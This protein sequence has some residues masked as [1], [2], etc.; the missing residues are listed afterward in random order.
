MAKQDKMRWRDL[1][2]LI[3]SW[4]YQRRPE[5]EREDLIRVLVEK[6]R[7]LAL[8]EEVQTVNDTSKQ[9]WAQMYE[10]QANARA[11]ARAG[12]K[13]LCN[14]LLDLL[15]DL[16][17]ELPESLVTSIRACEDMDRLNVAIRRAHTV[18]SLD[19]LNF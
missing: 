11:D 3:F 9:T 15:R 2:W 4:I 1:L 10:A 17:G 5:G 16:F 8:R 7:D 18:T 13:A 19:N 14:T 6:Q 12:A